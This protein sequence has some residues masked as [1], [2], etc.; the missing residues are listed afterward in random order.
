MVKEYHRINQA[1]C[2]LFAV[3]GNINGASG[4]PVFQ[5][6]H[7]ENQDLVGKVSVYA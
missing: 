4:V 6:Q 2:D 5:T 7:A 1:E 3:I